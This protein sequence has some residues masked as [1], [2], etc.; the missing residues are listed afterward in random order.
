MQ[1]CAGRGQM[2]PCPMT[3]I[4]PSTGTTN[5]D[6]TRLCTCIISNNQN[7]PS[8]RGITAIS[9]RPKL[10]LPSLWHAASPG[11]GLG[12]A[13]ASTR[14]TSTRLG[15]RHVRCRLLIIVRLQTRFRISVVRVKPIGLAVGNTR[16]VER[17]IAL[18]GGLRCR[19]APSE[20]AANG[21]C[22]LAQAVDR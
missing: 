5:N 16:G 22:A 14:I 2:A 21:S 17:M 19:H 6:Y 13:V 15:S 9:K 18:S 3:Y 8:T 7:S 10:Y 11:L 12:S 20:H 4:D 1:T